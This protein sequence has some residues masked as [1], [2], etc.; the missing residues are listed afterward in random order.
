MI[1]IIG[2]IFTVFYFNLLNIAF[3]IAIFSSIIFYT[4]QKKEIAERKIEKVTFKLDA[5]YT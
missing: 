5:H 4:L 1:Y 3:N 2:F